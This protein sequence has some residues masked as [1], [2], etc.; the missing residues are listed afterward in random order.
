MT[1]PALPGRC[2]HRP[3]VPRQPGRGVP[4]RRCH[5][6]MPGC[7]RW[8]REMNLAETA[9]LSPRDD[10]FDLRWF[11]PDG[12]GRP[13]RTRHA[14][15]RARRSGK[16]DGSRPGPPPASIRRAAGSPPRSATASSNST[17]RRRPPIPLPRLRRASPQRCGAPVQW[18][19]RSRFDL[20]ARLESAEAVRRATPDLAL[21]GGA[22]LPRR[23]HHRARRRRRARLR[24]P[25]LRAAVGG[26]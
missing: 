6:M 18:A 14:G 25:L 21:V 23:H 13:L 26:R 9:F 17:S 4:A 19:G 10:G 20:V 24:V 11:T 2:L 8:R 3:P 1:I 15:E 22:A 16:Q 12:R 7:S 5:A